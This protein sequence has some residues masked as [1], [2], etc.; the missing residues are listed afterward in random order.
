MNKVDPFHALTEKQ[1]QILEARGC[2][3]EDWSTV[4]GTIDFVPDHIRGVHFA[5][6][7]R[8]GQLTGRI[9][10]ECGVTK[11]AGIYEAFIAD[12]TVGNGVRISNVRSHISNYCIADHAWIEDVGVIEAR[13]H[14]IYGNGVEVPVLNEGGGR[15]VVLFNELSAQFAFLQALC[16][17]RH[18]MTENLK[19]MAQVAAASASR[20]CGCIGAGATVREVNRIVDVA[21]GEAAVVRGASSLENGT[22]LSSAAAPT[23]IGTDVCAR[24]FVIAEGA[25]V[26]D[27]ALI[28][29][30]YIG[31]G[32]RIGKQFSAEGSLFFANCEGYHGEACSVFAGP[33]TVTHHKAT[34]LIAGMF[35]F[36]NA[37][38]GTNQSN[39]MYKLGPVHEGKLERGCKTGSC[40]YLMWPCRVGPFSV[41]LGK[42]THPF[43]LADLPFSHVEA[44]SSGRCQVVPGLYLAAVGTLRDGAKWPERDRRTGEC[45]RDLIHFPVLSPY[46]AGRLLR[47]MEKLKKL[48]TSTGHSVKMVM[49]DG[50]DI[51]RPFLR[52]GAKAY[53]MGLEMYVLGSLV[54][55]VDQMLQKLSSGAAARLD[56]DQDAVFSET[57]VDVAGQLMPE[58]R[59][60][61][62]CLQIE[63]G[64]INSPSEVNA[65]LAAC[66]SRYEQ[67]EWAWCC[68]AYRKLFGLSPC[69][70]DQVEI[71]EAVQRWKEVRTKFLSLIL[72]DASR[73]FDAA[74][75][76]GFGLVLDDEAASDFDAVR[77]TYDGNKFVHHVG[78]LIA[79]T[80]ERASMIRNK[81]EDLWSSVG[82]F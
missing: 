17:H 79:D 28:N 73:E 21:I 59:L 50:A 39:H 71:K 1:I 24:D 23:R 55:R 48:E 38:S 54:A 33:Y 11:P 56:V 13:S 30:S 44:S 81:V 74:A 76:T 80:E 58:K 15:E 34:L 65:V 70:M 57:W 68:W 14:A 20:D 12:C 18:K 82:S 3:A 31:Q 77:G 40:S 8:L 7:V 16:R 10:D 37:G 51:R 75:R 42:H 52:S 35:S 78:R 45:R 66:Y 61:Q 26:D 62:L 6:I 63:T 27:G 67:D 29:A 25:V 32:C 46:T 4:Y 69:E 43:D 47:G 19:Q 5:G 53:R 64:E 9:R 49:I 41:V 2:T 36:Y 60:Q 72:T 22:V